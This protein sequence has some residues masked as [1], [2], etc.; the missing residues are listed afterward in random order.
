M[1]SKSVATFLCDFLYSKYDA[2]YSSFEKA[3]FNYYDHSACIA[4]T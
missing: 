1:Y 4:Y 3:V 2:S